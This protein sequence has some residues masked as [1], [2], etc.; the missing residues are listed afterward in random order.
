M[1]DKFV[2]FSDTILTKEEQGEID[3]Y[4]AFNACHSHTQSLSNILQFT[5]Y[6]F[7]EFY[8]EK[9]NFLFFVLLVYKNI[10]KRSN[11]MSIFYLILLTQKIQCKLINRSIS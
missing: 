9:Q 3:L 1:L 7:L 11:K 2:L 5:N 10:I 6:S 4:A 8:L